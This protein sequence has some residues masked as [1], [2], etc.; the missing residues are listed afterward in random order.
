MSTIGRRLVS[1]W[2]GL[3]CVWEELAP[4][5]A[6]LA[7]LNDRLLLIVSDDDGA[8][9]GDEEEDEEDKKHE[10]EEAGDVS[11]AAVCNGNRLTT[12]FC[13]TQ[14][15]TH[16]QSGSVSNHEHR[17]YIQYRYAVTAFPN[18]TFHYS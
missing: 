10:E 5:L 11:A 6:E 16:R 1:T 3:S 13:S 9:D 15:Q 8:D 14:Q 12:S 4:R 17:T 18:D 7:G 2:V